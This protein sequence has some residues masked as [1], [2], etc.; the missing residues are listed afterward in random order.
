MRALNSKSPAKL[1]P[2]AVKMTVTGDSKTN[3]GSDAAAD[4]HFFVP[5]HTLGSLFPCFF[6]L[7][8]FCKK[9]RKCQAHRNP[10]QCRTKECIYSVQ[11]KTFSL[12]IVS[13]ISLFPE[14]AALNGLFIAAHGKDAAGPLQDGFLLFPHA[15]FIY[16]LYYSG[17]ARAPAGALQS[18]VSFEPVFRITSSMLPFTGMVTAKLPVSKRPNT[19]LKRK[20]T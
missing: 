11:H 3:R 13:E 5:F 14:T 8:S 2:A 17:W 12:P 10:R 16:M 18:R 6:L 9:Y 15:V 20:P 7:C 19:A 4:H 1:H